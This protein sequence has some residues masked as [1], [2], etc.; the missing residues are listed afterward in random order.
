M[1]G[2]GR[3]TQRIKN[4]DINIGL[5]TAELKV[6]TEGLILAAKNPSLLVNGNYR[7]NI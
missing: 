5:S 3:Y 4:V 1:H 6:E 2:H 7:A